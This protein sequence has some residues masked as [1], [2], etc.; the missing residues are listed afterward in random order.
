[1]DEEMNSHRK[2]GTWEIV[3]LPK[4]SK[5]IA[6]K[7]VFKRK[8][9]NKGEIVRYKARFVAK[10]YAQ[11]YG[12]DYYETFSPVVR[13]TTIRFLIA[14]AVKRGMRIY[15]MDAETVFLQGDLHEKVFM[16]QAQGYDD[17]SGRVYQ[18]KKAIYGLKQA[19]RMWNLK[20][21]DVL[22][23]H[24]F[25]RSQTDPCV[26]R[27]AGIILAIYVDDF[28]I[29]YSS[30]RDLLEVKRMLHSNFIMKDI[31]LAATCLG[32]NINQG[33]NFIEIDQ[34]HY[35]KQILERF[36]MS[37]CKPAITPSDVNQKLSISMWNEENSL[38]GK[39]PYQEAIGSLLYLSGATRPDI[40][41]AVNDMSR[42]NQNHA[43]PHWKAVKR[44]FRYLAGTTAFKIR[45]QNDSVNGLT[46]YSDADW[47]RLRLSYSNS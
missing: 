2:N 9:N 23:K 32:I 38:V 13:H 46:A 36:G 17:N 34:C 40:S 15:Q 31:G 42:F 39:V 6:G 25:V 21:N 33:P 29:L 27:R 14:L 16:Q 18:L 24:G 30:E 19:S 8:T 47:R 26:Y 7:W 12:R 22:L 11:R 10:G 4:G 28:I 44:I 3:E 37:N 35:V 41:F 5:A 45:Y 1:M 20:L 43:E